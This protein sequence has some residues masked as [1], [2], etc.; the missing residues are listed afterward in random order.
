LRVREAGGPSGEI[1]PDRHRTQA[2]F[3]AVTKSESGSKQEDDQ[4]T[5]DDEQC[6]HNALSAKRKNSSA[7]GSLARNA[8]RTRHPPS[9]EVT[10][11][12]VSCQCVI[13]GHKSHTLPVKSTAPNTQRNTGPQTVIPASLCRNPPSAV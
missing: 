10:L 7:A 13:S 8:D 1:G 11:I 4:A 12:G 6:F 3:V 2:P 9:A 5:A